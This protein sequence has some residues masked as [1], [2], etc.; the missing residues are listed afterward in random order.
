MKLTTSL[1]AIVALSGIAHAAVQTQV[2]DLSATFHDGPV[3]ETGT[4]DVAPISLTVQPFDTGLGT[5]ESV[6]ITWN[7]TMSGYATN[8]PESGGSISFSFSGGFYVEGVSYNGFGGGNGSGGP[9][10]ATYGNSS[11]ATQTDTFLSTETS[12]DR[13]AIWST[14]S[15]P[16]AFNLSAYYSGDGFFGD[17]K[18]FGALANATI[19]FDPGSSVTVDYNYSAIPEPASLTLLLGFGAVGTVCARRKTCRPPV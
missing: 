10:G 17:Y 1:L 3:T 18:F 4:F 16:S 5:L 14:L 9:V 2:F 15:A 6:D 11:S 13:A 7:V 19:A 8:Y 12:P